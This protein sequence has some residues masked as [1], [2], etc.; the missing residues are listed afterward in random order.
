V[1]VYVVTEKLNVLQHKQ[2]LH[3][4]ATVNTIL[5]LLR[6]HKEKELV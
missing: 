3:N 5:T 4:G 1:I 6:G 2:Q